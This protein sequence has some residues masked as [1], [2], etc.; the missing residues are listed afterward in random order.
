MW[1]ISFNLWVL[2]YKTIEPWIWLHAAE[3]RNGIFLFY[4]QNLVSLR[5]LMIF[6]FYLYVT[7]PFFSKNFR[8]VELISSL[9]AGPSGALSIII[10]VLLY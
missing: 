2:H 6:S 7:V 1:I 9:I 5:L 3:L 4:A 10:P 8:V